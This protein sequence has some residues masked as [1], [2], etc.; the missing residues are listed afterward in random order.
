MTDTA[1]RDFAAEYTAARTDARR[2]GATLAQRGEAQRAA[3]KIERAADRAGVRLDTIALDEA[4]RV[5][6]YS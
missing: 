1:P 4:A 6:L 5:A 3:A 2:P